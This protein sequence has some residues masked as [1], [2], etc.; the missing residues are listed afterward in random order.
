MTG[1]QEQ[2]QSF[3]LE[4][5]DTLRSLA[6]ESETISRIVQRIVEAYR[7]EKKLVVFGNGGSAA[8]AQHFVTELTVRFE[9]NRR[10][11]PALALATNTSEMTAIGNDLGFGELFSRQVEAHVLPGDVVVGISTSGRSVN[12][13]RGLKAA[14]ER[15]ACVIAL[16]GKTGGEMSSLT[17]ICLRVPS[18]STAH[19]QEGHIAAI[20]AICLLVEQAL[21]PDL[22]AGNE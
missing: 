9:K 12:V 21:C 10:P 17:D 22:G 8:D 18:A 20:H 3:L 16:A 6:G 5:S 7:N 4:G 1:I 19:V 13:L 2:I 11:L 14:R 15:G